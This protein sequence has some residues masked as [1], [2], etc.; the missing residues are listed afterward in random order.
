MTFGTE[1]LTLP[2][3]ALQDRTSQDATNSIFTLTK[4]ELARTKIGYAARLVPTSELAYAV[5]PPEYKP[6]AGDLVLARV[7]RL[8]RHAKIHD[9]HGRRVEIFKDDLIIGVYGNRYATD[10]YEG[11]VPDTTHT[12]QILSVA[13]VVGSVKSKHVSMSNPTEMEVLG[14]VHNANGQR[15]NSRTFTL[16]LLTNPV[17]SLV[18][19]HPTHAPRVILVVGSSMNSGKTT[20]VA[21]IVRGLTQQGYRVGAGK[22]T[23]TACGN[24]KWSYLDHGAHI[25]LDFS[26]FGYPST[27]LCDEQDLITLYRTLY[28][29]LSV[30]NTDY[31]VFEIADGIVQRETV[32]L[33]NH[34]E[35]RQSMDWLFYAAGDGLACEAG[36][37]WLTQRGLPVHGLSGLVT[38]STLAL[39]EAEALTG[40]RIYTRD[41]LA[42]GRFL[43]E[44]QQEQAA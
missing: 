21:S 29:T 34:P 28:H 10:Q 2:V 30:N 43:T 8:G 6:Q 41:A 5:T 38:A 17:P 20:T 7:S 33:L 40:K 37:R 26:D 31:L 42:T 18:L 22:I 15:L 27:Y 39:Q 44:L 23:G 35:L 4:P 3:N 32:M 36:V 19:R 11:Y 25:A 24:D 16:P 13:T 12:C 1:I 9:H 14:I